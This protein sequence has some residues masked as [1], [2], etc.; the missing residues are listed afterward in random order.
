[1]YKLKLNILLSFNDLVT[2]IVN[3]YLKTNLSHSDTSLNLMVLQL[4]LSSWL[5][6]GGWKKNWTGRIKTNSFVDQT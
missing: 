2:T 4:P 6:S 1:M 5:K 3:L